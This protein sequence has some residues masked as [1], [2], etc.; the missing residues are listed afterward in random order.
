MSLNK[1]LVLIPGCVALGAGVAACTEFDLG[2][3]GGDGGGASAGATVPGTIA[4]GPNPGDAAHGD[5]TTDAPASGGTTAGSTGASQTPLCPVTPPTTLRL[6]VSRRGSTAGPQYVRASLSRGGGYPGTAALSPE[7][8]LG[9]YG[10]SHGALGGG[11]ANQM[12][13]R[14]FQSDADA[15]ADGT[16]EVA[17]STLPSQRQPIELFVLADV[18]QSAESAL[19]HAAAVVRE[20]ALG[21]ASDYV[22]GDSIT[23][24]SYAGDFQIEY[25][26][27]LDPA[28]GIPEIAFSRRDGDDLEGAISAALE[29]DADDATPGHI[30]VLSDGG[31]SPSD[32][33][34]ARVAEAALGGT[35]VSV[36]QM[37]VLGTDELTPLAGSFL[38]ALSGAGRGS[39][40][41]VADETDAR[42]VFRDRF[43]ATFG[44]FA[45][46]VVV[47]VELPGVLDPVGLVTVP[48]EAA[49]PGPA[50]GV[51]GTGAVTPVRLPFQT[52]CSAAFADPVGAGL[53]Q[54]RVTVLQ[55]GEP[56]AGEPAFDQTFAAGAT[57]GLDGDPVALRHETIVSVV[58]AL[59]SKDPEDRAKAVARLAQ[60]RS[61]PC[62]QCADLDELEAMLALIP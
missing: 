49:G 42:R 9:Y 22:D 59:R 3:D 55:A 21:M 4:A 31:A 41:Y 50:G 56:M 28:V 14:W 35:R 29:Y 43:G 5:E 34:L 33:L 57:L 40:F 52:K 62:P 8:F 26:A 1:I 24:M 11:A 30:L 53:D 18:S 7:E 2:G 45:D 51:L 6:R 46:D 17:L 19:G 37:A 60:S 32:E 10:L 25:S 27:L 44:V 12:S 58:R 61:G 48:S 36:A 15:S 16:L 13:L 54:F 20:I 39:R 23:V 47:R 38:D